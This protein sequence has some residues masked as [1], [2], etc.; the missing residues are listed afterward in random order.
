MQFFF[1]FYLNGEKKDKVGKKKKAKYTQRGVE[2]DYI[3]IPKSRIY[4]FGSQSVV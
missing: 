1:Q 3:I 4:I 2:K